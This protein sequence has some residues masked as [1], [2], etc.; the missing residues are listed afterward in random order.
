M[1]NIFLILTLFTVNLFAQNENQSIELPD[2]VITGKENISIPK[3]QKQYPDYISLLSKD[4]LTPDSPDEEQ[5][6]I[7]LPEVESE[8][9]NLGSYKQMTNAYLKL[10]GGLKTWPLGEFYYND[11]S[12]NFSYNLH[13][14][15]KN[16]LEFVNNAGLSITGGNIGTKY[17]V[18]NNS[19]F[20][21]GLEIGFEGNYY[22]EAFNFYGSAISNLE[23]T[24]NN[25]LAEISLNYLSD[26]S[27]NLGI[28][29]SDKIYN[30]KN[31]EITENI[32]GTDGY[33]RL[34]NESFALE[35]SGGYKNQ[36]LSGSDLNFGN[37]YYYHT[38]ALVGF[39]YKAINLKAGVFFSESEDNSFFSPLAYGSIKLNDNF[40][41]F[42]EFSPYTEFNT[43]HDFKNSNRYYN[44]NN[45]VNLFVENKF[46]ML[47]ALRYEYE[48][49]FEISGGAGYINSDNNFYF[50][51]DVTQG[52]FTIHK[53]DIENT[54]AFLN[55]LFRKGPFGEFYAEFKVEEVTGE[56][57]NRLPYSSVFN[58]GLHYSYNWNSKFGIKLKL[59]YFSDSYSDL[60]NLN[61]I[62]EVMDM[63]ASF[64]YELFTNF[65]LNLDFENLLD[66]KY[67]YFRNY[68]AKPFD[69]LIGFDFRW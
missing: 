24:T 41:V 17:F 34:K 11:W 58:A 43:L 39:K 51:D 37:Q 46:N 19:D 9:F 64:Y 21:P 47:F 28:N 52:F 66:D 53:E 6:S 14:F 20:L 8:A 42:G 57:N 67:Y 27:H 2:F 54:Y 40:S 60:D 61:K 49:Y 44:F 63:G 1:K 12:G 13:L 15:G 50:E 16:E 7:D 38:K 30:Q 55:L 18:D 10:G 3:I 48:K 33:Y 32:F 22:Y 35:L 4:F 25:G 5:T 23:R 56:N 29:I 36:T 65:N 26:P 31:D 45:F 69:M 68:R 62:P 59:N